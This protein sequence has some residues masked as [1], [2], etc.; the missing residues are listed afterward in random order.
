MT[1]DS[2]PKL[3]FFSVPREREKENQRDQALGVTG[4]TPFK[5][6]EILSGKKREIGKKLSPEEPI[7]WVG[8]PDKDEEILRIIRQSP[9]P[10]KEGTGIPTSTMRPI[11]YPEPKRKIPKWFLYAF[12]SIIGILASGWAW[13]RIDTYLE[14]KRERMWQEAVSARLGELMKKCK[15][16]IESMNL[17]LD[18]SSIKRLDKTASAAENIGDYRSAGLIY[19][20]LGNPGKARDMMKKCIIK[21]DADGALEIENAIDSAEEALKRFTLIRENGK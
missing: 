5:N 8:L 4:W 10:I 1:K 7:R 6:F 9:L 20:D 15:D 11:Y 16:R 2:K 19:V 14:Q 13:Y 3:R 17:C 21:K 12:L 18:D